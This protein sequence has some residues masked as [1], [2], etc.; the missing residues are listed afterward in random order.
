MWQLVNTPSILIG[1]I[2]CAINKFYMAGEIEP[3]RIILLAKEGK[4]KK[5]LKKK[6]MKNGKLL[7]M[8]LLFGGSVGVINK[9]LW[10]VCAVSKRKI[11][12]R[13]VKCGK[14]KVLKKD[15]IITGITGK[16]KV[17]EQPTQN[18]FSKITKNS[19]YVTLLTED[20]EMSSLL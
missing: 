6:T 20:V 2:V 11:M 5:N 12:R 19:K 18:Y 4:K 16:T 8:L 13:H 10:V 17:S 3:Q 15:K 9:S 14:T 1:I 7:W